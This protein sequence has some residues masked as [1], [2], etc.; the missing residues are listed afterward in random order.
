MLIIGALL[1]RLFDKFRAHRATERFAA[2]W[3]RGIPFK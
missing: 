2:Q 1:L 3:L